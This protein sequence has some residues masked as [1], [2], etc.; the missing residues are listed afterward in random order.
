MIAPSKPAA[1]PVI[2]DAPR[3][4]V[5]YQHFVIPEAEI[6]AT[7]GRAF[8]ALYD[9]IM[10][11]KAIPAGPPFV[12]YH[13]MSAPWEMDVCAPVAAPVAPSPECLYM[14]LPATPT[15]SLVHVG[16][17]ETVG[18][19]YDQL[20]AYVEAEG[21]KVAGPPREFYLSPPETP[22]AEIQTILEWPIEDARR[23]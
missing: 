11:I 7:I 2:A 15:V 8:A 4:H 16:P 19:A 9:R 20:K 18:D 6:P 3:R 22:P 17:Y 12:I 21:L 5:V 10:E 14:E 1:A 13:S 23:R